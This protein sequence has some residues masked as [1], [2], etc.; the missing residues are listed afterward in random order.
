MDGLKTPLTELYTSNGGFGV[1]PTSQSPSSTEVAGITAG[2]Y[3]GAI[4][5]G[6][7]A[8]A[9]SLTSLQAEFIN[10]T[11]ISTRLLRGGVTGA[12]PLA[13]H[14][15]YNQFTGAWTCANGNA[16]ADPAPG[17]TVVATT[18]TDGSVIP[19]SILPK[20]CG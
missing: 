4:T 11:G 3:V 13:V 14:M 2:K 9:T 12:A 5:A 10:T 15:H 6:T 16:S 7:T 8:N 18:A 19:Q 20:S 1:V 17:S